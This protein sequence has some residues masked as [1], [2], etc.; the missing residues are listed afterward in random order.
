M[1]FPVSTLKGVKVYDLTFGKTAEQWQ[2]EKRVGH[3]QS[4]RYNEAYRRRVEFIQDAVFQVGS[5]KVCMSEDGYWMVAIGVYPPKV[6]VF[7]L[8][9]LS[10][11]FE[12]GLESEAVDLVILTENYE[13]FVV[14][15]ENRWMEFHTRHGKHYN[16]RMPIAG[17]C[18]V[19]FLF[20]LCPVCLFFFF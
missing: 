14:L 3:V 7:D 2:E 17:T 6:K 13:K 18:L 16:M 1:T 15:R 4:L 5:T 12:R 11:K 9:H 8:S 19:E 20:T 10:L